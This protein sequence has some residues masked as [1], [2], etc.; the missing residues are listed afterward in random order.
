MDL[1]NLNLEDVI[2]VRELTDRVDE[3]REERDNFEITHPDG[4]TVEAPG[5]WAGLNPD[6]AAE[7]A[8]LEAILS[9]LEGYGGDE[10]WNGSWYPGTLIRDS[11]FE[12]YA[13]ELAEDVCSDAIGNASWP[14]TCIDWKHAARELQMDYSAIEIDGV[15]YWY[16]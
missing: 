1:D 7:L 2:D 4:G 13:Q 5:E 11:Y 8:T 14:L 16:R 6:D 15:T 10:Q 3:L 9:E 12:D